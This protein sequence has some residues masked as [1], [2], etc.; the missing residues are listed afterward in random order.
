MTNFNMNFENK[1]ADT[2]E[3]RHYR[4]HEIVELILN[5]SALEFAYSYKNS[6]PI[7]CPRC[8][9]LYTKKINSGVFRE[10]N[11]CLD[12]TYMF[13]CLAGT[14]FQGTKISLVRFFQAIVVYDNSPDAD[15]V[16]NIAYNIDVSQKTA[17]NL[18][19]IV[20][21]FKHLN[22]YTFQAATLSAHGFHDEEVKHHKFLNFCESK[23]ILINKKLFLDKIRIILDK[24]LKDDE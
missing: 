21:Q 23:K 16:K 13:N 8:D 14:V 11:R 4:V 7:S 17:R 22:E 20:S 6:F 2:R 10:L 12:C 3:E 19:K 9:S 15:K 24:R 1:R 18:S 5:D